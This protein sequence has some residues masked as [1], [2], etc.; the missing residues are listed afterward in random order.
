MYTQDGQKK[1]MRQMIKVLGFSFLGFFLLLSCL[2]TYLHF[3]SWPPRESELI[4]NFHA[5]RAAFEH[6]HDMVQV[7][8]TGD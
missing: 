8:P 3:S 5:Y 4:A 2:L 7:G 1:S 6:L